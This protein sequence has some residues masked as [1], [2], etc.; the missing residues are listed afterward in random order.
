MVRKK[1][2]PNGGVGG[3]VRAVVEAGVGVGVRTVVEAGVGCGVGGGVGGR[4]FAVQSFTFSI[5]CSDGPPPQTAVKPSVTVGDPITE[6]ISRLVT[7]NVEF[8]GVLCQST[9]N[10]FDAFDGP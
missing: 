9:T 5:T 4:G 2:K 7:L 8:S 1:F 10:V 3:S 6:A